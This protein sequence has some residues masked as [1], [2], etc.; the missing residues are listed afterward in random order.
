MNRGKILFI[1]QDYSGFVQTDFE[2]LSGVYEVTP[3]PFK[4]SKGIATTLLRLLKQFVFLLLHVR[5]YQMIYMWFADTHTFLPVFFSR[6]TGIRSYL[7]IGGYDVCR[8]RELNYG[9]FCSKMR[10]WAALYSMKHSTLNLAVSDYVSRKIRAIARKT[11][12]KTVYNCTNILRN[13]IFPENERKMVLTVAQI[14][15]ERTFLLKGIDTFAET[16]RLL[17]DI[18]FQVAGMDGNKLKERMDSLPPNVQVKGQIPHEKLPE[19]FRQAKVYCQLSR[20]ESFGI[21]LAEAMVSGCIPVVTNEGGMPEVVGNEGYIVKRDP[22]TIAERI[23]KIFNEKD[24]V[25]T[26]SEEFFDKF[27]KISREKALMQILTSPV[28]G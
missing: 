20:S 24:Q 25:F 27:S 28:S 5:R 7:V 17:P 13:S 22:E 9:V 15:S 23:R 4:P 16:A 10:G 6:I 1:Y 26:P 14:S 19:L 11:K 12:S 8:I 21:A 2:I 18:L 3:C